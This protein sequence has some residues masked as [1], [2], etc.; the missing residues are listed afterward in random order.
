MMH[1][2]M[3]KLGYQNKKRRFY[4]NLQRKLSDIWIRIGYYKH[5][6]NAIKTCKQKDFIGKKHKKYSPEFFGHKDGYADFLLFG[7]EKCM[8]GEIDI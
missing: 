3:E 1:S 4:H 5:I 7:K 2:E 8:P 6:K